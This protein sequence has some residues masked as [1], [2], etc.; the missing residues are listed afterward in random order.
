MNALDLTHNCTRRD[1]W[2]KCTGQKR[3]VAV[4]SEA[5]TEIEWPIFY[6]HLSTEENDF[7]DIISVQV[8]VAKGFFLLS[9]P[10]HELYINLDH[11]S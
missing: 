10:I 5:E 3:K 1:T 9:N 4:K 11:L 6:G 7:C 2:K 8:R